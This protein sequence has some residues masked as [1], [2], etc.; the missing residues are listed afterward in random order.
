MTSFRKGERVEWNAHGGRKG[1]KG[2]AV[3]K[4]INKLTRPTKVKGHHAKASPENPQ[5]LVES[6]NGGRAAHR[7]SALRKR[8]ST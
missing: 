4:V 6:D 1:K 8:Q 7:P 3:G 5:Y 2:T